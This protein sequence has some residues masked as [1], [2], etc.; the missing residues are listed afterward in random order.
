MRLMAHPRLKKNYTETQ[1]STF[2]DQVEPQGNAR[3]YRGGGGRE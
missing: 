3:T 2:I 1:Q